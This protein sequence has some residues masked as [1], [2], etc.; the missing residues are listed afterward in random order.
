MF[1][2]EEST[3]L[4]R[5]L[6]VI[7]WTIVCVLVAIGLYVARVEIRLHTAHAHTPPPGAPPDSELHTASSTLS[8]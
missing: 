1:T 7:W 2:V 4:S 3:L 5:M 8:C 6:R